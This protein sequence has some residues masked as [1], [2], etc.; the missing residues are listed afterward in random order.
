MFKASEMEDFPSRRGG[1]FIDGRPIL[2]D[3]KSGQIFR[4]KWKFLA[5]KLPPYDD[6]FDAI[7]KAIRPLFRGRSARGEVAERLNA[8]VC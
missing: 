8:A 4:W 6:A 1:T 7:L 3:A 2:L 5:K